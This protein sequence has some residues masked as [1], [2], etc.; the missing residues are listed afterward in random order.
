MFNGELGAELRRI[1]ESSSIDL[2]TAVASREVMFVAIRQLDNLPAEAEVDAQQ[3]A[4][5]L[6]NFRLMVIV[7]LGSG[8]VDSIAGQARLPRW[9]FLHQASPACARAYVTALI[10]AEIEPP[11]FMRAWR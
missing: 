2:A 9:R 10:A 1:V 11:P 8:R 5:L 3:S 6:E 4:G 7:T